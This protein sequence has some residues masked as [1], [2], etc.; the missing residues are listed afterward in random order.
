MTNPGH[1]DNAAGTVG[2]L[3][4]TLLAALAGWVDW[5]DI[6]HVALTASVGATVGFITTRVWR[7]AASKIL[8]QKNKR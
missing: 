5:G 7:W 2:G 6:G 3:L 1:I 4:S 8:K